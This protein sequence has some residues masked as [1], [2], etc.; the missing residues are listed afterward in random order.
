MSIFQFSHSLLGK[1]KSSMMNRT[2]DKKVIQGKKVPKSKVKKIIMFNKQGSMSWKFLPL[3][4]YAQYE[5]NLLT[6]R[7]GAD[8]SDWVLWRKSKAGS[9]Q[10][11]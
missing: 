2:A 9:S 8:K 5:L 10:V 11:G 6:M 7:V 1:V 3:F 4:L